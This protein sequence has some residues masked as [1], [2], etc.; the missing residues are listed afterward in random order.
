MDES[1]S[2][3]S[4]CI[5]TRS[6]PSPISS[7]TTDCLDFFFVVIHSFLLLL[8][9]D[10][11]MLLSDVLRFM[12]DPMRVK[13]LLRPLTSIFELEF[14][15]LSPPPG[16]ALALKPWVPLFGEVEVRGAPH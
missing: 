7:A 3:T 2:V 1:P 9:T 6:H 13:L 15:R 8:E 5:S 4:R 14:F 10:E 11:L 12:T 16:P